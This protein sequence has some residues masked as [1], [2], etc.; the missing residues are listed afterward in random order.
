MRDTALIENDYL[1]A[2]CM[3]F[4]CGG[5]SKNTTTNDEDGLP[6]VL[7]HLVPD[8]PPGLGFIAATIMTQPPSR[9]ASTG[10]CRCTSAARQV[11]QA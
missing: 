10:T 8:N 7:A 11:T 4:D 5:D 1:P 2:A 6:R 9:D 3:E